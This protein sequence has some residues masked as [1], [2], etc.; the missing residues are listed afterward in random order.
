MTP[1]EQRAADYRASLARRSA[2]LKDV[3]AR[4]LVRD[5]ARLAEREALE[6]RWAPVLG[7]P[8]PARVGEEE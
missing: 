4:L 3:D 5:P 1:D 7:G 8:F 6:Q 2:F